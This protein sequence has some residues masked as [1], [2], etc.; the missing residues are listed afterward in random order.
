MSTLPQRKS[1]RLKGYDYSQSGAYFVTICA[2]NRL[3]LFGKI[4]AHTPVLSTVGQ[5]AAESWFALPIHHAG[6]ELDAFVV[7]PNHIHGIIVIVGTTPA[8]SDFMGEDRPDE[9]GLVPTKAR[10]GTVIGSYKSAVTRTIHE[11]TQIPD[12]R[13]WQSRYYDHIIRS[14]ADLNRIREYVTTNPARWPADSLY[15]SC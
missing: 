12:F 1:P 14:E 8:S 10:L 6:I 5:I 7:M 11:T 9:A 3:H 2:H 4:E 15:I 13:V